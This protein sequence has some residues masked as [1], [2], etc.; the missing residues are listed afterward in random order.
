[1]PK[2]ERWWAKDSRV[3]KVMSP[4]MTDRSQTQASFTRPQFPRERR[5][6]HPLWPSRAG[7]GLL[8]LALLSTASAF[9]GGTAA[10]AQ[11]SSAPPQRAPDAHVEGA[12]L[13]AAN[14]A[15]HAQ[16]RGEHRR[17][18]GPVTGLPLPRYV[19]LKLPEARARRGPSRSHRVDWIYLQPGLPLRITAEFEQWRRV[20]DVDGYGGWVH[21]SALSGVRTA[22]VTQDLAPLR[23]SPDRSAP[24]VALLESGVIARILSCQRDWCRLAV[25]G[26]RGWVERRM[27]W[28]VDPEEWQN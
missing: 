24:E 11:A 27:I 3:R 18:I 23:R 17:A 1:M 15:A 6:V 21:Y 13:S 22:L 19:S 14:S 12:A 10:L 16:S 25:D 9:C 5:L 4:R 7:V 26:H 8:V 20:E 2:P 28:G